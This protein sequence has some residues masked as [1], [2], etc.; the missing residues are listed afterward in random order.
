MVMKSIGVYA[1]F[2]S[3]LVF[4]ESNEQ[5]QYLEIITRDN[6]MIKSAMSVDGVK[7]IYDNC[8]GLDKAD[9]VIEQ[10]SDPN[11]VLST[12]LWNGIQADSKIHDEVKKLVDDQ[13]GKDGTGRFRNTMETKKNSSKGVLALKKFYEERLQE[14]LYGE[15]D[16][17]RG[18][19]K[20]LA[21]QKTFFELYK[22]QLGKNI[23]AS[24][25]NYCIDAGTYSSNFPL[26]HYDSTA[27]KADQNDN[28]TKLN[29]VTSSGELQA[30]AHWT[31][32]IGK[33]AQVC[34]AGASATAPAYKQIDP[35]DPS[36]TK[37]I[38]YSEI[39][40]SCE[41]TYV[42]TASGATA[43][44]E[45]PKIIQESNK[46]SCA[47]MQYIELAKQSLIKTDGILS[48]FD[49][50]NNVQGLADVEIYDPTKNNK[51]SLDALT[52][53]SS[54]D[55]LK[56]LAEG[57]QEDIAKIEECYKD[58]AIVNSDKCSVYLSSDGQEQYAL[59]GELKIQQEAT[60]EKLRDI[61]ESNEDEIAKI[62]LE[63]GYSPDEAKQLATVNG[64]KDQIA[65]RFQAK[66][67]A[68]LKSLA[69]EIQ[70]HTTKGDSFD[71]TVDT[72]N[73]ASIADE[74]KTRPENFS[75]LVH[76]NNIVSSYLS[77]RGQ[78]EDGNSV[79]K[80]NTAALAAEM[81]N[82]FISEENKEKYR[83]LGIDLSSINYSTDEIN[84][85]F[86]ETGM[87]YSESSNDDATLGVADINTH[88]IG[89]FVPPAA[90]A[91]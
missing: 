41:T 62:L 11:K 38:T 76:F 1:L 37:I 83:E 64:I 4:A 88:I 17:E 90:D 12:C 44:T 74:I 18:K 26:V 19:F 61:D 69:D 15:Y 16:P 22:T 47:V 42:P 89:L 43:A 32:C 77:I 39:K 79:E 36:N 40:T 7:D 58:G 85:R 86:A 48:E 73:I 34:Y 3:T 49:K 45:C 57:Q 25:T 81:E 71:E 59:L 33:I 55:A 72:G 67:D 21:T 63:E 6:P 54:G 56:A 14:A 28:I 52:T 13:S 87:D 5:K 24:L 75:K 31:S 23:I 50:M 20:K 10:D 82:S 35:N 80:Q 84:Q 68:I 66:K 30:S 2:I 65:A 9:G 78:D 8:Y 46:R 27:V 51:E 60:L 91:E 53:L 70:A 29:Q